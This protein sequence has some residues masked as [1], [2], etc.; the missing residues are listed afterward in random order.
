LQAR[1]LGIKNIDQIVDDLNG[2]VE[3][4]RGTPVVQSVETSK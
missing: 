4:K 2:I 1:L 3:K